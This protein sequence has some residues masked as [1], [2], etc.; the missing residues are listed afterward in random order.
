V[1]IIWSLDAPKSIR[2]TEKTLKTLSSGGKKNKKTKKTKKKKKKK[3][4]WA[5]FFFKPGFFPTLIEMAR[6]LFT[7][8]VT[9]NPVLRIQIRIRRVLG[10]L[11]PDPLVRGMDPDPVSFYHQSKIVRKTLISTVL[12][13]LYDFLFVK[14]DVNEPSKS[15][16]Q[17][18]FFFIMHLEGQWRK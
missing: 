15:N 9:S 11:D 4:H 7:E 5:G 1:I 3:T 6:A 16:K 2:E 8:L 12:W 13:H 18:N 17:K 14:N 10:V